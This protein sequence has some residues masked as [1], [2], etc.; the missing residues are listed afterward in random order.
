MAK[1]KIKK[2]IIDSNK[3]NFYLIAEIGHNHMG[4]L[5]LAMKMFKEAKNAGASAVKLQKR[6]NKSLYVK[7]FYNE[8]YNHKNSYGKTY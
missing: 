4:D 6:D 5:N 1:F 8:L 7:S 2:K 3:N